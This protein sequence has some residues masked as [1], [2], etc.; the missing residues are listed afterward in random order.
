MFPD[1]KA[2]KNGVLFDQAMPGIADA[3]PLF[4]IWLN[5]ISSGKDVVNLGKIDQE[6]LWRQEKE[7]KKGIDKKYLGKVES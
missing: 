7:F 4:S 1:V 2:F 3:P 6:T 5:R